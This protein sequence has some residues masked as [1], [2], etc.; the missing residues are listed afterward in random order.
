MQFYG[1]TEAQSHLR[2]GGQLG[3]EVQAARYVRFAVGSQL[4]WT[5]QHALTGRDPCDGPSPGTAD[6]GRVCSSGRADRRERG[7]IDA[8]GR[9]FIIK[10]QMLLGVYA[11]AT[12]SF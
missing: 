9:R 3:V 10:D 8:P 7:V 6:D 11:Q 1:L 4:Q 2:Y 12:A 5:T